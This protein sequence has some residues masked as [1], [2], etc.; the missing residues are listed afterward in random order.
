MTTPVVSPRVILPAATNLASLAPASRRYCTTTSF[1]AIHCDEVEK[2]RIVLLPKGAMLRVIGP[3]A[4]LPKG[5]EV[6]VEHRIYHVF[7][8]DLLSS[9]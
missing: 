6:N 4:L 1:A 2:A 3:S 9:T 7:E 8:T 5:F